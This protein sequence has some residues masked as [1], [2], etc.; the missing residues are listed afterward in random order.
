[1]LGAAL[2]AGVYPVFGD[3]ADVPVP[4]VATRDIGALAARELLVRPAAGEVIDLEGPEYTEQQV[5][6]HLAAVLGRPLGVVTIPQAGWVGALTEAGVPE[7]L[8]RELAQMYDAGWRGVL[9][10]CGDRLH[11]GTTPI[12][13]TLRRVV[14]AASAATT[15]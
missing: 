1:M 11:R 10:P 5:A 12:E 4:M 14:D 3:R 6:D 7:S 2:G 9:R 13:E 15:A 8:A